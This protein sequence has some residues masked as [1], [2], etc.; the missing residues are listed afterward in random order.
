MAAPLLVLVSVTG[1]K[2][3]GEG[4]GFYVAFNSLDHIATR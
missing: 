4:V 3:P 1:R 2:E